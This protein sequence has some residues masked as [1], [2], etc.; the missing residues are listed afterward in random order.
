MPVWHA[1][2]AAWGPASLR[3]APAFE[4]Q[5]LR[6]AAAGFSSRHP[7]RKVRASARGA[8]PPP[9]STVFRGSGWR[10]A[11]L[12]LGPCQ[13]HAA[14]AADRLPGSAPAFEPQGLRCAAAG[15]SSRHPSRKV[16]AERP[17][18]PPLKSTI[19]RIPMVVGVAG[20]S[21]LRSDHASLARC[22]CGLGTRLTAFGACVRTPRPPLRCGRVLIPPPLAQGPRGAP[23]GAAPQIHDPPYSY[24][25]RGGGI[26]LAALGPCQFGTLRVRLGDPPHCVRRLRSNP[27]ASAALRQGSHPAT[28]R[29]RSARSAPRR[30]PS[31]P[32]STV[33]LWWV[34]VDDRCARPCQFGTLR[35]RGTRLTAFGACVRTPRP[36][37]RCGRV[38]IPPPL[39][40]GP[41]GAPRGAAPQIHDPP[42]SY[43]GRGGGIRTHDL[44]VPKRLT[45]STLALPERL[46]FAGVFHTSQA[47]CQVWARA[48][49]I[50]R[51]LS[52]PSRL[53][54]Q[55]WAWT[56]NLLRCAPNWS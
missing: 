49:R 33:F 6:C 28:P 4:P 32:R 5:G 15:F 37:L 56:C 42:Y 31:N 43:G 11:S 13:W 45:A 7:S 27:K 48:G 2:R 9:R 3:S 40:Q 38:L 17:E 14:R 25:G 47:S 16:R 30:R 22:A 35:V 23:R 55:P 53:T 20:L 18:A 50:C 21:S 54:W 52:P 51:H 12:Q 26:V 39:A 44:F 10:I 36:P 19:H 34:G 41:R 24:G 29:A 46:G 1:A 8:A